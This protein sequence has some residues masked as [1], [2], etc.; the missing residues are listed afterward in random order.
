MRTTG[1]PD[2]IDVRWELAGGETRQH[3]LTP[4]AT[5]MHFPRG[6][7]NGLDAFIRQ[8]ERLDSI[9]GPVPGTR[10]QVVE[11]VIQ[12]IILVTAL[13]TRAHAAQ[14]DGPVRELDRLFR[15]DQDTPVLKVDRERLGLSESSPS[16]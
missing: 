1:A 9:G 12:P 16:A 10:C 2:G 13:V 4:G 8:V 14:H 11:A 7:G 6:Y 5:V 15:L 3:R